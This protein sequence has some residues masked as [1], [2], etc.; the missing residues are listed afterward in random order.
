MSLVSGAE[1]SFEAQETQGREFRAKNRLIGTSNGLGWS[2][3]YASIFE[4]HETSGSAPPVGHPNLMYLLGRPTIVSRKISGKS[5]EKGL[6]LTRQF[7]LTPRGVAVQWENSRPPEILQIYLRNSIYAG[8]V[9]QLYD[10]EVSSAELVSRFTFQDPLL[11]QLALAIAT[12]LRDGRGE[13][14]LYVDCVAQMIA[15]HLAQHYSSCS[16]SARVPKTMTIPSWKMRRLIEFIEEHLSSD[17]SLETI[18]AEVGI[19]PLYLPRAFKVAVGQSPHQYVMGRRI[20][21]AKELL[22]NSDLPITEVALSVGFSSQ[23]H[24]SS[25]F[26]RRVG[27][28]PAVYRRQGLQ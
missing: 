18:G 25:S 24:L 9:H 13:D 4:Q 26:M 20:E 5:R 12:K 22:R 27:V 8:A 11:E 16:R 2:S 7:S 14:K 23:P 1:P 28:S 3:L 17:L 10:C 19:S 15:M 6:I 21:R